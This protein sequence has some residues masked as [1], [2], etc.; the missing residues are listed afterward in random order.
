MIVAGT[1]QVTNINSVGT[2]PVFLDGGTFQTNGIANLTFTNN[3]SVTT[4]GGILDANGTVLKL[5]G[6]I[7]DWR[8]R[9]RSR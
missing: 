8:R 1:V 3:F 9:L 6:T 2:G 7:S 5:S 4:T